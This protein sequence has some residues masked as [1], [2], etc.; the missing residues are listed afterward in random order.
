MYESGSSHL[1]FFKR[2]ADYLI[3]PSPT[4]N[5][6]Y[7]PFTLSNLMKNKNITANNMF[8]D[9]ISCNESDFDN[10]SI[11]QK[12]GLPIIAK[13][14]TGEFLI[15]SADLLREINQEAPALTSSMKMEK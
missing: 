10:S 13:P 6:P 3:G 4:P 7:S 2:Q 8:E 15:K 1:S 9:K 5:D 14:R 12:D 11:Y